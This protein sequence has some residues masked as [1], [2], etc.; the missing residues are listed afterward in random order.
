MTKGLS[1]FTWEVGGQGLLTV[2]QVSTYY[3]ESAALRSVSLRVEEGEIVAVLGANGAGKTTLLKTIMGLLTPRAGSV[4]FMGR[5]VTHLPTHRIVPLG[6]SLVPEGRQLFT[7]L[8]VLQNLR[9]GMY[10]WHKSALEAKRELEEVYRL[11][12]ILRDRL[13]QQAGRLSGGQQQMLAVARAMVCRP[14]LLLLDEPSQGLAPLVVE[15]IFA[16]LLNL[17]RAGTSILLV[18]QDAPRALELAH[19]CYVLATG[20]IVLQG[21]STSVKGDKRIADAYLGGEAFQTSADPQARIS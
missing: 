3:G 13:G 18:E 15:E 10:H 8:T 6:L 12:P 2:D 1:K 7:S 5:D 19:R 21:D 17:H 4:T 20:N 9:L 16:T 11:F 14:K